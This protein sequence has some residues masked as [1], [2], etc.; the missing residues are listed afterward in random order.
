MGRRGRNGPG[1]RLL[2]RRCEARESFLHLEDGYVVVQTDAAH[3]AYGW[4]NEE[5]S[6]GRLQSSGFSSRE[7]NCG[8][9]IDA[10]V[11]RLYSGEPNAASN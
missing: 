9:V 5:Q 11:P 3:S 1:R 10:T 4:L 8:R 2:R 7:I 6:A